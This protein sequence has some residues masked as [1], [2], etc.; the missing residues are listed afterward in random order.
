M[1]TVCMRRRL[2]IAGGRFERFLP[3]DP[4]VKYKTSDIALT[5]I[6]GGGPGTWCPVVLGRFADFFCWIQIC[7][8]KLKGVETFGCGT[9]KWFQHR[10]CW[11]KP[12]FW[13]GNSW[14]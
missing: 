5:G 9:W 11:I 1:V 6:A 8:S 3:F 7:P 10:V 2:L 4:N 13:N 12:Q 14:D